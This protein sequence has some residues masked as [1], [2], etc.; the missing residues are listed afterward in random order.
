MLYYINLCNTPVQK[1][2]YPRLD[3]KG[4]SFNPRY[5]QPFETAPLT[6][7]RT[8]C[9]P[10]EFWMLGRLRAS[11]SGKIWAPHFRWSRWTF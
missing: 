2:A 9:R 4:V 11:E 8:C 7:G 6:R 3:H 10:L 1:M 5:P